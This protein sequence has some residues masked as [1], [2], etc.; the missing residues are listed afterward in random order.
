MILPNIAFLFENHLRLTFFKPCNK[1]LGTKNA[2][3]INT[4]VKNSNLS[5]YTKI[6]KVNNEATNAAIYLSAILYLIKMFTIK[7]PTVMAIRNAKTPMVKEYP[8]PE[9]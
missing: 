6:R 3:T 8:R 7:N 1:R 9:S 2:Y 4:S 5:R